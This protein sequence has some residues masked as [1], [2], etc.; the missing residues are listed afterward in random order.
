MSRPNCCN[1]FSRA[2]L[3]R[4]SVAEAGRGLPAIEPGMPAPAGTGL[5]RRQFVSKAVGATL[6]VYGASKIAPQLFDEGIARAA[7]SKGGGGKVLVSVFAPG[8]WDSLSMLYPVSDPRYHKLRTSLAMKGSDGPVFQTDHR[9]H[10]HPQLA[11]LAK[12]HARGRL[13]V[14]PTI[15]YLHPDQSHFT[16]R[17]FWEVGALDAGLTSGWLGRLID[18]IGDEENAMQALSL[19][20]SLAPSLATL[21]NP[22]ATLASPTDYGFGTDKVWDVPGELLQEAIGSLGT[23]A[24]HEDPGLA[25][26]AKAAKQSNNL[27]RDLGRFVGDDGRAKYNTKVKYPQTDFGRRLQSL[28]AL[29]HAG[30][31]IKTVALTAPGSYDTHAD[32]P[33]ALQ[34][35]LQQVAEGL[36]AFQA[37]IE[38]RHMGNRVMTLVWSEFGRRAL[39]NESNGTDHGAAGVGFLMGT[40]VADR[41]VGEFRGLQKGLDKDGNLKASVDF[42]AVY[43][44]LVEQWFDVDAARIVPEGARMKR[45]KLVA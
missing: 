25:A 20:G 10:W 34:Q 45:M 24:G 31:P 30:F 40:R 33:G 19:D 36:A 1:E 6:T 37:D 14:F 21:K 27:R 13:T 41:M 15:G 8:G 35:G 32:Q 2:H 11:P 44:S 4:R 28:A 38:Q 18:V 16:S 23:L 29:L 7:L 22:V 17:H 26:A 3:L 9:L 43:A 12:L 42:R 5:D 39:Q